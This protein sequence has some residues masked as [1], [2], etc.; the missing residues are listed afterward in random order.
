MLD[1]VEDVW[2]QMELLAA[3]SA[4]MMSCRSAIEVSSDAGTAAIDIGEV[5]ATTSGAVAV[6]AVG[7]ASGAVVVVVA[8]VP[9]EVSTY[10][11]SN[12]AAVGG[13]G[14]VYLQA[15]SASRPEGAAAAETGADG[16]ATVTA[17]PVPVRGCDD[18]VGTL[19]KPQLPPASPSLRSA[20]LGLSASSSSSTNVGSGMR[21]ASK[22]CLIP[23][24]EVT[25]A[26][27]LPPLRPRV[28]IAVAASPPS[29]PIIAS[30]LVG[31]VTVAAAL[32][33]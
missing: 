6:A 12:G 21:T 22:L 14:G 31:P 23:R 11:I 9:I 27:A 18:E 30:G 2:F 33:D 5:R 19:T 28:P 8:A 17:T 20:A 4:L 29:S 3:P 7:A 32:V 26:L 25:M 10:F 1:G 24:C 15:L 13:T 16:G